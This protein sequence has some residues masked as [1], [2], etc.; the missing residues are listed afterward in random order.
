VSVQRAIWA[1]VTSE[2]EW[3]P[4]S[5]DDVTM[6]LRTSHYLGA[7][8]NVGRPRLVVA[9]WL[10]GEVVAAQV[11]KLPSSRRLPAS[12]SWLE[13]SRW[14]LTPAAGKNAG[15]RMHGWVVR[16]MRRTLPEVTT[17][18]SYSDPSQGHTGALYRACNWLWK[19]T[20]MRLRPPP[21]GGGSWDGV[22]P[23]S[24]KDRWVFELR[25][26]ELRSGFL[27]VDDTA[28]WRAWEAAA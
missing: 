8:K 19:P 24:V 11:W 18:L 10:G 4:A 16:Y 14:C 7:T 25:R 21:S 6:L 28:A 27:A 9:G 12:G 17:L 20:W 1:P 5:L 2:V 3:T 23:Q 22:T 26:D 15:S 13:L